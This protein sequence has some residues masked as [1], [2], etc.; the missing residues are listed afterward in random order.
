[1]PIVVR[2]MPV[3]L[4]NSMK[5]T[6]LGI[7]FA[8]LAV[9]TWTQSVTG[10][11]QWYIDSL[12]EVLPRLE[13]ADRVQA[14]YEIA[15]WEHSRNPT[16]GLSIAREALVYTRMRND[17]LGEALAH[18]AAGANLWM[19]GQYEHAIEHYYLAEGIAT[20][21]CDSLV[22]GIVNNNIG[23]VFFALDN[24]ERAREHFLRSLAIRAA[25]RDS[26]RMGRVNLN[27]GLVAR[28]RGRTDEAESFYTVA[29]HLSERFGDSINIARVKHYLGDV[30][31]DQGRREEAFGLYMQSREMYT[32]LHDDN[33]L[34]LIES[35]LAEYSLALQR[36]RTAIRHGLRALEHARRTNSRF[37]LREATGVLHKAHANI[38]NYRTAYD[39]LSQHNMLSDSLGGESTVLGIA[40]LELERRLEALREAEFQRT[41]RREEELSHAFRQ[42]REV[43]N[44]SLIG[45]GA[46]LLLAALLFYAFRQKQRANTIIM[47]K[48]REI[49]EINRTLRELV[50]TKDWIFSIIGHDLRAPIG[51]VSS[52]AVMM[53]E[54]DGQFTMREKKELLSVMAR[55]AQA[56][57]DLLEHLLQWGR[58]QKAD[59]NIE[60]SEQDINAVVQ[61]MID[62]VKPIARDKDI[63]I[64]RTGAALA[65]V[66]ADRSM[67]S[68]VIK[69]LLSNAVKF[70]NPGGNVLV[71]I[72]DVSG[73]V[74]ITVHDSG[75]GIPAEML[76]AI[77]AGE[78][79]GTRAG[80]ADEAG[81]GLG[82]HIVREFLR[83]HGGSL[84][85]DSIEG[86]WSSFTAIIPRCP[87]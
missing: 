31:F 29:L 18:A 27:L 1:M 40:G 75:T 32:A 79:V 53:E 60:L 24:L 36:Y 17:S 67:I 33:G 69:N 51:M 82:L 6:V 55:S 26:V 41:I 15:T 65:P 56:A 4:E 23:L 25:I 76:R 86:E 59:I 68:I 42:E 73:E 35:A 38:G 12:R 8:F 10:Q 70:S 20:V 80:T 44:L 3:D 37:A 2:N 39:Y 58:T 49:E 34:S 48:N 66:S 62:L 22:L 54:D 71:R 5:H 14:L 19:L 45:L 63:R 52:I 64:E 78:M 7:L 50:A 47:K 21:M 74:R 87:A 85:I 11:N 30:C 77:E 81:T 28:K 83:A 61:E 16:K 84:E 13:G 46:V 43:R 57:C 72:D 9:A